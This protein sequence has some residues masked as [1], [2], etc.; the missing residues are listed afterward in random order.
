MA[1]VRAIGLTLA[2]AVVWSHTARADPNALFA[3]GKQ[4]LQDGKPAEACGKFEAALREQPEAPGILLNLGLCNA[5][6]DKIATALKWF[7]K[8]QTRAAERAMAETE[9]AAKLQTVALAPKVPTIKIEIAESPP[10]DAT[11]TVDGATIDATS[12][13]RLE[14][15]AGS[16]V[17]E[18]HGSGLATSRE[19]ID[20]RGDST[21]ETVVT[22]HVVAAPRP[23]PPKVKIMVEVDRGAPWRRRAYLVGAIG[24]GLL[25]AETG[26]GVVGRKIFDDSHDLKT[27]QR[28][29][30]I[31][32]YG[33]TTMFGVGA[34][35][36]ATAVV[37]YLAAPGKERIEQTAIAP[38]AGDDHVGV[39]IT[40]GF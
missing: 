27:R 13:A 10:S 36:V 5:Q 24:A 16:H 37:I 30:D 33:G 39:A 25:V 22:L 11:V 18:L 12:L 1:M 3:E 26:L 14:I 32:R 19:T 9:S 28:W 7:R 2:V 23:T 6:Q 4:L 20:V 17:V 21:P 34:A 40:G 35:A 15:D 8:A 29:K 38:F 31:V